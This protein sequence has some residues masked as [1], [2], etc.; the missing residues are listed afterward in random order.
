MNR[1]SP[2][3]RHPLD[4]SHLIPGHSEYLWPNGLDLAAFIASWSRAGERGMIVGPHGSGKTTLLHTVTG[5]PRL[6]AAVILQIGRPPLP[7]ISQ[8]TRQA[9]RFER[10]ESL[11]WSQVLPMLSSERPLVIDGWDVWHAPQRWIR[12]F[13]IQRRSV[14]V[15]AT[16]HRPGPWPT[17]LQ[18]APSLD[19]FRDWVRMQLPEHPVPESLVAQVF[20]MRQGNFR[21][22]WFEL[23][24]A[25]ERG[26]L[27]R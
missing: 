15:L 20:E 23:Y 10:S 14:A 1:S 3:Q 22:A 17:L 18:T 4:A 13:Q 25:Y 27:K 7:R 6:S 21:E 12:R 11:V 9:D 19:V 24:D 8:L 26:E 5:H 16:S 2:E